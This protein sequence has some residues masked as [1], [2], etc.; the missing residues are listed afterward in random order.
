MF[1]TVCY[2][3]K[4]DGDLKI[5]KN[6]RVRE[7]KCSDG[8]D[9]VFVDPKLVWVLQKVRDHFDNSVNITKNGGYRNPTQNK[10]SGGAEFSQHMYGRA[11]D[12]W[13]ANVSPAKVA[14]YLETFMSDWGGIGIY[15]SFVHVDTRD[16]RS[17]WKG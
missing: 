17:R 7:F 11:A 1:S 4:N 12:I 10:K 13:V 16:V 14:E 5:S 8:S 3:V 6:F 2:S 15:N 9:P